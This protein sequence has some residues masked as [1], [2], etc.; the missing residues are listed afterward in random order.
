MK[1]RLS[2]Q[3]MSKGVF[4]TAS[5]FYFELNFQLCLKTSVLPVFKQEIPYFLLDEDDEGS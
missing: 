3:E 4:D 5:W 1:A 2:N